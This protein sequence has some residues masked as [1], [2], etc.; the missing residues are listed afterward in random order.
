MRRIAPITSL[1]LA[2]TGAVSPFGAANASAQQ[3]PVALVGSPVVSESD[4]PPRAVREEVGGVVVVDIAVD[5]SGASTDCTPVEVAV[6]EYGFEDATCR[7]WLRRARFAPARDAA[8]V[9]VAGLYR[10]TMR[11][12]LP[13]PVAPPP[14][15]SNMP[16]VTEYVSEQADVQTAR[17]DTGSGFYIWRVDWTNNVVT[18]VVSGARLEILDVESTSRTSGYIQADTDPDELE[19]VISLD[20]YYTSE[21][22]EDGEETT[23]IT[24]QEVEHTRAIIGH[25]ARTN[26]YR[27]SCRRY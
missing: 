24:H 23:T 16:T 13:E 21:M 18:E 19:N 5:A 27:G 14:Q 2:A 8:G 1:L 9:A 4:Y 10:A 12:S 11:W 26:R 22:D 25:Y 6:A 3:R 17:C 15:P 20:L 7:I